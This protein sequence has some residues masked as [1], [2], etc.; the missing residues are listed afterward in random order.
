M[1]I[2][3]VTDLRKT[4]RSKQKEPGLAGSLRSL[5]SPQWRTVEAVKASR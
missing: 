3:E 1:T 2:I 5:V 4:F